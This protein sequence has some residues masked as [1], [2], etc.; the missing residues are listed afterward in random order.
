MKTRN[1]RMY[2]M[3][4]QG[5]PIPG[6]A[7]LQFYDDKGEVLWTAPSKDHFVPVK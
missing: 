6:Q 3:S 7:A 2:F 4:N 1:G 5:I